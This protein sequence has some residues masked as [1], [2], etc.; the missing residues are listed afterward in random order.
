[1]PVHAFDARQADVLQYSDISGPMDTGFPG[2]TICSSA[3]D[4]GADAMQ[5]CAP[6]LRA[7]GHSESHANA[8]VMPAVAF[9][10]G[11][12]AGAADG[13]Q[14][15]RSHAA[16]GPVG[17]NISE[18]LAY[19]LRGG[20]TQNVGTAMQV[21]RLTPREC[22]RLQGFPDDWTL[23]PHRGKPMADGPRY[24]AIGNSWAVPCA[25]WIGERIE[26]VEAICAEQERKVA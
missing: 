10:I 3:K 11:S 9:A 19:S 16:G 6:T 22:E 8:G 21:R 23:V 7:G 24:K 1:M 12:H 18:E 15:N 14:T 13:D 25:R 26:A 20:R 4:H 17:S 2:P 5:D